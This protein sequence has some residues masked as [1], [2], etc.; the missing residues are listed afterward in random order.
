MDAAARRL[1]S[2]TGELSLNYGRGLFTINTPR[3]KSAIGA[4]DAAAIDLDGVR[5]EARTPFA[6]ITA[7][8][9]DGAPIGR[10][11][12]VLLT[13]VGRAQ[14]TGQ[15]LTPPAKEKSSG[16]SWQLTAEGRAPVIV[17]PV[18][19]T[20][21]VAVPGPAEVHVLDGAGRRIRMMD[22][23]T[24]RGVVEFDLTGAA[25]IWCEVACP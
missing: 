4:L 5:V 13:A 19:A 16:M 1:D 3:T 10:S 2:D 7:T 22:S 11:R 14:N 23:R 18:R 24:D 20:V 21:R 25:S 6:A 8:S 15:V 9:L 17:E 12:R